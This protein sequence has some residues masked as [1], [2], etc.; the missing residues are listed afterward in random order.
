[1][2]GSRSIL[3]GGFLGRGSEY[4][5]RGLG[6][7]SLGPRV[8]VSGSRSDYI[9]PAYYKYDPGNGLPA[10][11]VPTSFEVLGLFWSFGVPAECL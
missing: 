4:R 8:Y 11:D 2:P 7:S 5:V 9:G 10:W 3:A 6:L 1:M